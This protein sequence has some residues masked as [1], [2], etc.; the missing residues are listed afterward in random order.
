MRIEYR[1]ADETAAREFLG[2][3]YEPPY[4]MYNCPPE[5]MNNAIPYN[6]DPSNNVYAMYDQDDRLVGYCSFGRDAQVPGGDYSQPALDIGMMIKP[7]LT[8]KGL[9][10]SFAG[11]VIRYGDEKY[12]P[13]SL[14]VTIAAFNARGIRVWEKHGFQKTQTFKRSK[15]G[16]EFIVML[17]NL[18]LD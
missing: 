16:M 10:G 13:Q 8:G 18:D 15:D 14:R 17:K 3:H 5:Q 9:G 6:I 2:W 7:E 11:D 4:E 12:T 1:P